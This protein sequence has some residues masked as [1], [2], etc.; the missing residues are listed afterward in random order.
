MNE[1]SRRV[2][3]LIDYDNL[4]ICASRDTPGRDLQLTPV[5]QLAQRYGTVIL[6]RA[7]AEWNLSTERLAVY[8]AGI[9]PAFAPVLRTES[10]RSGKSL[11]DT[12]MVAEGM[13]M[14]WT[15]SPDVVVLAT[16]DKDL[17][18]LVRVAKQRGAFVVV[19]GSD[20]TAIPLREMA[21]EHITYRQCI[22]DAA[23]RP[24]TEAGPGRQ[25]AALPEPTRR[26]R[27]RNGRERAAAATAAPPSAPPPPRVEREQAPPPRVE[28][29]QAPPPRV[30]REQASAPTAEPVAPVAAGAAAESESQAGTRRRRRR[31]SR[32]RL[33]RLSPSGEAIAAGEPTNGA[34]TAAEPAAV[35]EDVEDE[36]EEELE[37]QVEEITPTTSAVDEAEATTEAEEAAPLVGSAPSAEPAAPEAVEA[38]AAP[39]ERRRR[40]TRR[41]TAAAEAAPE[42]PSAPETA[43][44]PAAPASTGD[45]PPQSADVTP[46]P[47]PASANGEEPAAAPRPRARRVASASRGRTRRV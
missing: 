14:L 27:D 46:A 33:E 23:G 12:V 8:K 15:L 21:D 29:E 19:L 34:A 36:V 28:R 24:G 2:V 32:R 13:D 41:T 38:P 20:F 40:T 31:G 35:P 3:L 11:A 30:E 44:A 5:V 4:Q 18:P 39:R 6:A 16:S 26:R 17:I 25:P 9:E 42:E 22:T 45:A 37:E 10:D 47:E 7:Y 1:R 43:E